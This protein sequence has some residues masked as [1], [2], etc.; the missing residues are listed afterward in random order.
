MQ[1]KV[2]DV[3]D[4]IKHNVMH[5]LTQSLHTYRPVTVVHFVT[6]LDKHIHAP[7]TWTL[8][9]DCI[10]FNEYFSVQVSMLPTRLQSTMRNLHSNGLQYHSTKQSCPFTYQVKL[11]HLKLTFDCAAIQQQCLQQAMQ[12]LRSHHPLHQIYAQTQCIFAPT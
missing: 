3:F 5:Y 6:M 11:K 9:P 2:N 4:E 1:G 8:Q 10:Q 12:Y 7:F